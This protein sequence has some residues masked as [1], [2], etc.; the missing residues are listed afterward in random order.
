MDVKPQRRELTFH[1][2]DEVVAD[3]ERLLAHGY[4][5][6]GNWDL[7]QVCEHLSEWMRYS[8]DG[9][10]RAGC[11]I[12]SML[13]LMKITI[14]RKIF[15]KVLATGTMRSGGPTMKATV[16]EPGGE[17]S[18][19]VNRLKETVQRFNGHAGEYQ[20]SPLF[21]RLNR[22]EALKLQLVHC[23]HHLSFLIPKH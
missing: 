2:L 1:D 12:G 15:R 16:P 19:A 17:A 14:G 21:G 7:A 9:Y 5:Q 8:I 23:A 3:A 10:P 20:P 18:A 22:D 4:S 6:A 11:F 13:W